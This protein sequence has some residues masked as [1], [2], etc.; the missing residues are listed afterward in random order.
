MPTTGI[1]PVSGATTP[2]IPN[3]LTVWT[4][5]PLAESTT[6]PAIH[7]VLDGLFEACRHF[8]IASAIHEFQLDARRP[9]V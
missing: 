2:R 6:A 8:R 9:R 5:I 4:A 1:I 3:S 7:A